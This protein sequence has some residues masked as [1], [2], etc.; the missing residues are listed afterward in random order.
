MKSLKQLYNEVYY[1][2][3]LSKQ[4]SLFLNKYKNY[5][6]DD[7]YINFNN[8]KDNILDKTASPFPNHLDPIGVYAYPLK[9]V[10]SNLDEVNYGVDFKYLRVLKDT[11]KSK[12]ILQDIKTLEDVL[13]YVR[14]IGI[15]YTQIMN[16]KD[17][18]AKGYIDRKQYGKL[19]FYLLQRFPKDY[20]SSEQ[21]QRITKMGIDAIEDRSPN[22]S[23]A[24]I[25]DNEPQQIIFFNRGAY[26]PVDFYAINTK[27]EQYVI[28]RKIANAIFNKLG[29]NII[30]NKSSDKFVDI[31][32]KDEYLPV[33]NSENGMRIYI[34]ID[35]NNIF[36]DFIIPDLPQLEFTKDDPIQH[37]VVEVYKYIN[38][39]SYTTLRSPPKEKQ[40][41]I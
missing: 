40:L 4:F 27:E 36:V 34:F 16:S 13:S 10:T 1:K 14:N 17:Y 26:N 11:S 7:L 29:T 19:F 24:I 6:G 8:R 41:T 37:I 15:D 20:M 5:S 30:G 18:A 28:E 33:Y 25:N 9:L 39:L 32:S 3:Y 31:K 35:Q 22:S 23:V 12:L 38:K 2:D 21:T